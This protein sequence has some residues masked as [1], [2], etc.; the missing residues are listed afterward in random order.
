MRGLLRIA[1][2]ELLAGLVLA[3]AYLFIIPLWEAPDEPYHYGN[4]VYVWKH[5]AYSLRYFSAGQPGIHQG[6]RSQ[7][8]LYYWIASLATSPWARPWA[9]K[10]EPLD[11]TQCREAAWKFLNVGDTTWPRLM[12]GVSLMFL[13]A[14]AVVAA[15]GV[16]AR[17]PDDPVLA[18]TTVS[19]VWIVPQVLF[20]GTV[21]SNDSLAMFAGTVL[22]ALWFR[23][24]EAPDLRYMVLLGAVGFVAL[25][26]K[27]NLVPLYLLG[28]PL[29]FI[30]APGPFRR[31]LHYAE[32]YSLVG[33][34]TSAIALLL[35]RDLAWSVTSI[36]TRRIGMQQFKVDWMPSLQTVWESY[37]AKFGWMNVG[38]PSPIRYLFWTVSIALI[39]GVSGWASRQ[40]HKRNAVVL[41]AG[42]VTA[43]CAGLVASLLSFG[44]A[45]GRH[46]F[47]AV[48]A[49]SFLGA[50]GFR[51]YLSRGNARWGALVFA[52]VGNAYVLGFVIPSAYALQSPR[53]VLGTS[54]CQGAQVTPLLYSGHPEQ[55]AFLSLLPGLT[56][57]GIVPATFRLPVRGNMKMTLLDR[58]TAEIVATQT[59][60]GADVSDGQF[61]YLDFPPIPDSEERWF[62]I[63]IEA[64]E[65]LRGNL[66]LFWSLKDRCPDAMRI[67]GPGDL[68]FVTY[69]LS[70][71]QR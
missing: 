68:R 55:Q 9:V 48:A 1:W 18:A 65:T 64:T 17:F 4:V 41:A 15:M 12:R 21:I 11:D 38:V 3:A 16:R 53:F 40:A 29:A 71:R 22:F 37:W 54:C 6:E 33:L 10:M 67:S 56:R 44:Q 13:L 46:L 61:L 43:Q 58:R 59:T 8:P 20:A 30:V 23:A 51:G 14:T 47:P 49:F 66:A 2:P 63:K 45:Q 69:H 57:V 39:L 34:W 36:L 32:A 25:F 50:A 26:A 35:R 19:M 31:R 42:F 28:V 5:G 52:L 62:I 24:R 70:Y 27:F 7:P 60:Q